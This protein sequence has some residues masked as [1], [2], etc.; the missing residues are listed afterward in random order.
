MSENVVTLA[1]H[2]LLWRK[3]AEMPSQISPQKTDLK[4]GTKKPLSNTLNRYDLASSQMSGSNR[5]QP[6]SVQLY[7]VARCY[8]SAM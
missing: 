3:R 1:I 2:Q 7:Q 5:A 8:H 6:K 4:C